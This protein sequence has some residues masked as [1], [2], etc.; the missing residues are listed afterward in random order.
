MWL[1]LRPYALAVYSGLLVAPLN[2]AVTHEKTDSHRWL[3]PHTGHKKAPMFSVFCFRF[4][5]FSNLPWQG[6]DLIAFIDTSRG[7]TLD[8]HHDLSRDHA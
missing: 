4:A 7:T 6:H 3:H 5:N 1:G 8:L 2:A